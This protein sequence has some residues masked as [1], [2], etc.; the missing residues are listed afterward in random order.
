MRDL[1]PQL[2][3]LREVEARI[4]F[5]ERMLRDQQAIVRRLT[6][7]GYSAKLAHELEA[8]IRESLE[9]LMRRREDI[10]EA[11]QAT[12]APTPSI[13]PGALLHR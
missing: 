1:D 13:P 4:A 2:L 10:V 6:S 9:I 11:M 5:A 3:R 8:N 12:D 7:H